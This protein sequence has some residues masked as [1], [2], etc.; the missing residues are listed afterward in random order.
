[1]KAEKPYCESN[2]AFFV[3]LVTF[4]STLFYESRKI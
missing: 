1:M 3:K 4:L 2:T